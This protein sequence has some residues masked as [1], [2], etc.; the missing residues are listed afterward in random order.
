[1]HPDTFLDAFNQVGDGLTDEGKDSL[2]LFMDD[3]D[4]ATMVDGHD[5]NKYPKSEVGAMEHWHVWACGM[6]GWMHGWR[7]MDACSNC[8]AM[9]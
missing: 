4:D 1:M 5:D 9:S 7:E 6:D 8:D 2:R 3:V